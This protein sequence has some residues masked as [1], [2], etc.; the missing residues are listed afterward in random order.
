M[1][2]LTFI[3]QVNYN[4]ASGRNIDYGIILTAAGGAFGYNMI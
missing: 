4:T 3:G 1:R 2:L